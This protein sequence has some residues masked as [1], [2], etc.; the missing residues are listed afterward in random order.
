[1][2]LYAVFA[3]DEKFGMG[4]KGKLPWY[5]MN[6]LKLFR[7]ITMDRKIVVGHRTFDGMPVLPGR[8]VYF[9]SNRTNL[10]SNRQIT[11][12]QCLDTGQSDEVFIA[13]GPE[14]FRYFFEKTNLIK[15]V[16]MSVMKGTYECDAYFDRSWLHGYAIIDEVNYPE[17]TSF[18]LE[19]SP[20]EYQYLDL[21]KDVLITGLE[22]TG[23]NGNTT[24]TFTNKLRFDLR[25]GYPLLTTKKM[26]TRGIIEELLF[27]LRGDTD[28]SVLA[29]KNIKIWEGNTTEEFLSSVG[30][31]YAP[32]V[33][34]PMYGYQW[35]AFGRKYTLDDSKRPV[36][37]DSDGDNG[38]DQLAYV[39]NLLKTDPMSRRI[40]MTAYNPVQA[41]EGVLY[42][43][44]SV[45]I[46]FYV[47]QTDYGVTWLDMLSVSRS[48]DLFLGAPFNIASYALFQI[49]IAKL[50]GMTPRYLNILLGDTH[51][52]EPHYDAI[53]SQIMRIPYKFPTI[54]ITK[55]YTS[56]EEMCQL[57]VSDFVIEG[58]KS[59]PAIRAEMVA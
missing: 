53:A 14:T 41:G 20:G 25:D 50:V 32:G 46:Q 17:F 34:G 24:G 19:Y 7:Q 57:T 48:C 49:L 8:D 21:A 4:N 10:T 45:Y 51:I 26:F 16:Y 36:N 56:I 58:Y 54:K 30:L 3:V 33:M 6:E 9:L 11:V 28:S 59:H 5:C 29:Q 12:K 27:F 44:H 31:P 55:E 47:E 22:R 40:I 1:M 39:V 42:P 18:V 37:I 38:V 23:R 35:R 13:G 43:C 52:Y 2:V 15:R